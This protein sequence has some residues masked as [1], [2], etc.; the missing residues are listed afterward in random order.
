MESSGNTASSL[1]H[2][3]SG[4]SQG[5]AKAMANED[6]EKFVKA[7]NSGKMS[8][9]RFTIDNFENMTTVQ[10]VFSSNSQ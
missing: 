8:F 6:L 2:D 7:C 5:R 4:I 1:Q 9:K 3:Y 10:S